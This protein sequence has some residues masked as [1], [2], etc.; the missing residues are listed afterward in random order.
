MW[1]DLKAGPARFEGVVELSAPDDS[2]TPTRIRRSVAIPAN[3]MATVA[4]FV[5]PGSSSGELVARVIADRRVKAEWNGGTI[6]S[7][8]GET[9]II[10]HRRPARGGERARGDAEVRLRGDQ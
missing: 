5:R 6:A 7:L 9:G 10:P 2:G 3:D 4:M 8:G 1:I